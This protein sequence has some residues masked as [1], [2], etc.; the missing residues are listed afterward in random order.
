VS[1]VFGKNTHFGAAAQKQGG[2]SKAK[3]DDAGF[4]YG[5]K[6][7]KAFLG[8]YWEVGGKNQSNA[9]VHPRILAAGV[10]VISTWDW[11]KNCFS[12]RKKGY[13]HARKGRTNKPKYCRAG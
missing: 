8:C 1:S 5:R 2:S 9:Q 11:Y 7:G 6:R 4:E 10:S 12:C 13:Q 3:G